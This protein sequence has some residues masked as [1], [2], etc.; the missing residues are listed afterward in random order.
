MATREQRTDDLSAE[1]LDRLVDSKR[2]TAVKRGVNYGHR[3]TED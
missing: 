2:N 3:R 1:D